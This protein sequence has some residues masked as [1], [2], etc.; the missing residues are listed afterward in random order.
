MFK[1]VRPWLRY[2]EGTDGA[3]ANAAATDAGQND[4]ADTADKSGGDRSDGGDSTVAE[5]DARADKETETKPES[6]S[7]PAAEAEK[8]DDKQ[9]DV[10]AILAELK[11]MQ[12]EVGD[13]K[14]ARAQE[15][16][17]KRA[18]EAESVAKEHGLPPSLASRLQ[19]KSREELAA[20]AKVLAQALGARATDPTQGKGGGGGGTGMKLSDA[21][22]S[23]IFS[24]GLK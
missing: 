14:A 2:I 18:A 16:E 15:A 8:V 3:Q 17:A 9:P 21:I 5:P 11:K 1:N 24:A 4:A 12:S 19:G 10:A 22:A 20:D 6:E 23:R 7:K 13:L